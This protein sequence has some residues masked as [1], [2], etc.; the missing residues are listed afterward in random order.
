MKLEPFDFR[1]IEVLHE[2]SALEDYINTIESQLPELIEKEK[3]RHIKIGYKLSQN[4]CK[5]SW[6]GAKR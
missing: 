6:Q 4:K 5:G 2:L 3:K 1:F